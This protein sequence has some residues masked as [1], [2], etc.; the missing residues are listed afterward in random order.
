MEVLA[1]RGRCRLQGIK[2]AAPQHEVSHL[3]V[4]AAAAEVVGVAVAAEVVGVARRRVH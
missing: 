3:V 1:E 4:A 2:A